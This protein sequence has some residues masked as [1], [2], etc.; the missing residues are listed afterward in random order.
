M[1]IEIPSS[2]ENETGSGVFIKPTRVDLRGSS[3][4]MAQSHRYF[5]GYSLTEPRLGLGSGAA[6]TTGRNNLLLG[7]GAG[8]AATTGSHN[9][10][11]GGYA[12]ADRPDLQGA[13]V[14]SN[15]LGDVACAW[16]ADG[17][18]EQRLQPAAAV[19]APAAAGYARMAYDPATGAVVYRVA[20]P[21]GGAAVTSVSATKA[22]IDALG[23]DAATL[24]GVPAASFPTR[25]SIQLAAPT[26]AGT[27]LVADA[28]SLRLRGLAVAPG[29]RLRM[30]ASDPAVL[31]LDA[32]G[33]TDEPGAPVDAVSLVGATSGAAGDGTLRTKT[34]V[35]G[36]GL[37]V[38]QTGAAVTI[39]SAVPGGDAV[40]LA[41]GGT[42]PGVASLV[43]DGIGPT[44]AVRGL[45]AGD[46]VALDTDDIAQT[47]LV[48]ATTTLADE[49]GAP[50]DA[51]S[52]VGATS[53]P[54]GPLYTRS[55]VAGAG[56]T[57][58][59]SHGGS[60]VTITNSE[61]SAGVTLASAG[62]GYSL[63]TDG[64]GPDL[65]V[66]GLT[67]GYGVGLV[68]DA[69]AVAVRSNAVRIV[70]VRPFDV[71]A[72]NGQ[73][74][75]VTQGCPLPLEH[76][77]IDADLKP[78]ALPALRYRA[79][80]AADHAGSAVFAVHGLP[81]DLA[82][83]GLRVLLTL[84]APVGTAGFAW[85]LTLTVPKPHPLIPNVWGVQQYEA[86]VNVPGFVSDP[87]RQLHAFFVSTCI[88]SPR[89]H[90]L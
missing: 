69:T 71:T 75:V 63:V 10:V 22:S 46:G 23:V 88:I 65:A 53:A 81:P 20:P 66:R 47:V 35:A 40:S 16:G 5:G 2:G 45:V 32:A 85:A 56:I 73:A 37:R 29:G 27:T 54:G 55:L 1:S 84:Q 86:T 3:H 79:S 49:P 51:S 42:G 13:I 30:D 7:V 4:T 38:T 82:S 72:T 26:G 33:L 12:A 70:P 34:L 24:G 64:V 58:T 76:W 50:G 67:A 68:A 43:A 6:I 80:A 9:V 74:L 11:L 18:P 14:L 60:A 59:A 28:A 61:S 25:E 90:N 21:D 57:L 39:E 19:A 77:P 8:G 52:L 62:G 44:L 15:G 87:G 89:M 83:H 31:T 36:A 17:T 78:V 48:R 41:S